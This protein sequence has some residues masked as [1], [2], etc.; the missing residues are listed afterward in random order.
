MTLLILK[1]T[2]TPLAVGLA[3]AAGR[4]WGPSVGG[5]IAGIPFT[6]APVALFIT[7]DRGTA[8]GTLTATAILAGT[9]SQAAFALAYSV[10]A[11][12]WRWY[13]SLLAAVAAFAAATYGFDLLQPAPVPALEIVVGAIAL[14][15]AVMPRARPVVP[16]TEARLVP[17]RV[18]I[19]L[20]AGVATAYVV[21]LTALAARLG[22]TLAG[23]LSPFPIFATVLIVFPHRM[24]G[25]AAAISACRGFLWGLWAFAAFGFLLAELLPNVGLGLSLGLALLA[26]LTVQAISL[27]IVRRAARTA[28]PVTPG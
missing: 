19:P 15:L 13:V 24:Q 3:T 9:A 7:L 28:V 2:V 12:R 25:G 6:S 17:T 4:R 1:L 20:R 16:E 26:A 5:W 14:A 10:A 18:D 21:V 8:F 22:P 27:A 11:V 23:L